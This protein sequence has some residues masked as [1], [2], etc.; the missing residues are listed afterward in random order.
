MLVSVFTPTHHPVFLPQLYE[1]LREQTYP[2]WE[3][4]IIAD[5]VKIPDFHDPRVKVHEFEYGHGKV[6][7]LKRFACQMSRGEILVEVDHDDLLT[8]DCLEEVV[9][10]FTDPETVMV[11]SNFAQVDMSWNPRTWSEYYGWRFRDFVYEGHRLKEAISPKPYPSNVSRIWFAPNHVRAWRARAYWEMGGHSASMKISDDH[12]LVS[13]AYL[14]GK[15]RHVDKCLYIYRVHGK[16]TWLQNMQEIQETMWE[17]YERYIWKI[18][19][20][21]AAEE[22]LF[23]L[24]LCGAIDRKEGYTS[25]DLRRGDVTADLNRGWPFRENTAGIIRAHDAV[26]HLENPIHTMNEA[27]RILVHGGFFMIEVPST[28]GLGA[29]CDPTH[30]SFWNIRSFKYYTQA[31]MRR[32][33]PECR[34][35][36]QV[37]K[38]VNVRRYDDLPYVQAHLIAVKDGERFHG[39]LEI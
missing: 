17:N 13:R 20:K 22:R 39:E 7:A 6:G 5:R 34:C 28:E 37:M 8:G 19:E 27:Y 31:S 10:A 3:W 35:R 12:D 24:D 1:S 21:W 16:N 29:F 9:K 11:Y 36:F 32:Y 33:L 4:V 23:K 30:R 38:L 26:E 25:V 15:I 2:D 18:I 14:H